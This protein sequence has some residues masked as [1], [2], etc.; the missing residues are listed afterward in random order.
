MSLGCGAIFLCRSFPRWVL[1]SCL[2][3]EALGPWFLACPSSRFAVGSTL[4]TVLPVAC[5]QL[6]N[7]HGSLF[8]QQ[9]SLLIVHC[10]GDATSAPHARLLRE[11]VP[12]YLHG[13]CDLTSDL[14]AHHLPFSSS[15]CLFSQLRKQKN[16]PLLPFPQAT[17]ASRYFLWSLCFTP[18]LVKG[19]LVTVCVAYHLSCFMGKLETVF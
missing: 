16:S 15:S 9:C 12:Y 19:I 7:S 4:V 5:Q 13:P 18:F 11:A 8:M 1:G 2:P 10:R 6:F 17:S 14:L 3:I